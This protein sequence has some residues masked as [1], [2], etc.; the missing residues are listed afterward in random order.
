MMDK[1]RTDVKDGTSLVVNAEMEIYRPLPDKKVETVILDKE[2]GK[3]NNVSVGKEKE[4]W[5]RYH[6]SDN[7]KK[8]MMVSLFTDRAIYRP[9]Q[10][11]YFSGLVYEQQEDS[12]K[13]VQGKTMQ[14]SLLDDDNKVVN[15]LDVKTND[16]GTFSHSFVLPEDCQT[17]VWFIKTTST[18]V[19]I[20]VEEYKRPT[21]EV[22]FNP[23]QTT[24]QTG[25]SIQVTGKATT[26][27]GA[28]V[29]NA[30]VKYD[31]TCMENNWWRM[32]GSTLHRAEGEALTDA[33]GCFIIPIHFLPV[34]DG[35][36]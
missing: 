1:N 29:Q 19:S 25:D 21:F 8:Q 31:I 36:R 4:R 6:Y 14:V 16:F 32:R 33:D 35:K 28:P 20:R 24:Y 7:E 27:A 13:V 23:V 10:T 22:T 34:S 12:V 17:G 18:T 3:P 9:G 2:T 5:N 11:V 30:R 15:T 26:F